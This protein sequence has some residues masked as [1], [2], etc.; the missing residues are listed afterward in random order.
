[1]PDADFF[2]K[3]SNAAAYIAG[4]LIFRLNSY[5]Q[6]KLKSSL[7]DCSLC[8]KIVSSEIHVHTNTTFKDYADSQSENKKLSYCSES[9]L[10]QV[11]HW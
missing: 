6:Q 3:Q 8:S 7:I 9:F 5:H 10:D 1:M 11:I 4:Y 2:Q